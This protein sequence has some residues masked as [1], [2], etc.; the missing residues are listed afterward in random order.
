M[1]SSQMQISGKLFN[2]SLLSERD[3]VLGHQSIGAIMQDTTD[4]TSFVEYI[5]HAQ[6]RRHGVLPEVWLVAYR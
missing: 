6:M 4:I 1:E 3:W 5:L 2:K